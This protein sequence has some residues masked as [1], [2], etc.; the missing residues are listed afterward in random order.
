MP[1]SSDLASEP[2]LRVGIMSGPSISFTLEGRFVSKEITEVKTNVRLQADLD[3]LGLTIDG[4]HFRSITFTPQGKGDSFVLHDV[5]IGIGF[6]W[7]RLEDQRFAGALTIL[8]NDGKLWAINSIGI[9]TYL[10]CVIASEMSATSSLELLQAHAVVSRSWLVAQLENKGKAPMTRTATDS[11]LQVWYDRDDHHL[12]D[13]CAD[14]HCQRYQGLT[15]AQNPTVRQAIS[16]TRGLLLTYNGRTCDARFSK[17]CGGVS[18]FFSSCWGTE[19][20]PYL[21]PIA[22][23]ADRSSFPDLTNETEARKWIL[24][25]PDAFCNTADAQILTQVLNSY[26]QETPD[27]F[28]WQVSYSQAELSDLIRQKSGIDFGLIIGLDAIERGPSGRIITLRITGTRRTLD[29]G[30]ELEIRRWLSPSHLYSSAFTVD[31]DPA[32]HAFTLHGAGWGHGVGLCQ[33]GAAVMAAQ[34]FAYRAIL[35][36]YF[37]SADLTRRWQ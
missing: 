21:A 1:S 34:G 12:F 24:A 11:A 3:G 30:K 7:Q 5:M 26:D 36:H 23:R 17:C 29:V 16:A 18:E 27:F 33:I 2:Q 4:Q 9:E 28:R 19:P 20:H 25:T 32:T 37:T 6:H 31:V 8:A 22:D 10:F 35:D 14:D 15:R 13:V